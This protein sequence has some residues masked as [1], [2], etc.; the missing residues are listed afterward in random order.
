M[1]D[2]TVRAVGLRSIIH[3]AY[4]VHD[5]DD[6]LAQGPPVHVRH[7]LEELVSFVEPRRDVDPVHETGLGGQRARCRDDRKVLP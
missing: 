2:G 3:D 7:Q 4:V 1:G 5:V 6:Q